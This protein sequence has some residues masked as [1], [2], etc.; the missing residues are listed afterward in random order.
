MSSAGSKSDRDEVVN[1]WALVNCYAE[2]TQRY[3]HFIFEQLYIV[4]VP[5]KLVARKI[6][7][8]F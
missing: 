7:D 8:S 2:V 4:V 1:K 3:A 6:V 5:V